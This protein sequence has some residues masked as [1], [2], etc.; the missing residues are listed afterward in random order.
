[1]AA[2]CLIQF[3]RVLSLSVYVFSNQIDDL[4]PSEPTISL[5]FLG[6]HAKSLSKLLDRYSLGIQFS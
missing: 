5:G 6:V 2:A 4:S 1:M 3:I